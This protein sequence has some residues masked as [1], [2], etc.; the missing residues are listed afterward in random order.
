MTLIAAAAISPAAQAPPAKSDIVMVA[1]CLKEQPPGTWRVV[2]ATDPKPSNAVAPQQT[3]MPA[4]PVVGT[5]Q[6]QLIG[7]SI[8]DLPSYR[9][10]TVVLKGLLIPANP[11][12]RLNITSVARV[13]TTCAP[14]K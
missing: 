12:S 1:G 3:E 4:M 2:N 14:A 7:V 5:K 8:F 10:H 6:F 9:D 13:A 11:V